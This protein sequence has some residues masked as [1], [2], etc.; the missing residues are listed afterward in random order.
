M[1]LPSVHIGCGYAGGDGSSPMTKQ[2]LFKSL[3]WSEEPAT[4]VPT[5]KGAVDNA[6]MKPVF[7]VTNA[8][9]IYL[10]VGKTPDATVSPRYALR[11]ADGPHDIYVEPG[12]K[13]V[14]VAA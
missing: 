7:R 13:A 6:Q 9:D 3:Q 2:A 11:A 10:S 4:G 12:D 14:W 1:A 8:V 5:A